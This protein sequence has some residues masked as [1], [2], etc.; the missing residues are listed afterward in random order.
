M[1]GPSAEWKAAQMVLQKADT[2]DEMKVVQTGVW[3]V[4]WWVASMA[5]RKADWME[6]L[7]VD[8]KVVGTVVRLANWTADLMVGGKVALKEVQMAGSSVVWMVALSEEK[9]VEL[10]VV[11]RAAS[12]VA[13]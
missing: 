1:V 4:V 9:K 2:M 6:A 3:M 10:L 11:P 7:M 12:L 13:K 5:A 8:L